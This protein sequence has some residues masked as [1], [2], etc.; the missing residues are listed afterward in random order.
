MI[1][2]GLWCG[3][4]ENGVNFDFEVKYDL[5]GHNESPQETLEI[6][7]KVVYTCC[8]NLVTLAKTSDDLSHGQTGWWTVGH[9]QRQYLEAKT[10]LG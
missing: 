7:S 9:R 4:V 6:F 5:E 8:P 10:G 1:D 2:D 3:K